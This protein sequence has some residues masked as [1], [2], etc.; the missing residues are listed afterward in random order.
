MRGGSWY[1]CVLGTLRLTVMRRV[2]EGGEGWIRPGRSERSREREGEER[3]VLV[4]VLEER[5]IGG[6][7]NWE[8]EVVFAIVVSMLIEDMVVEDCLFSTVK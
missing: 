8:A 5:E 1:C 4:E 3:R 7:V 2:F 6:V